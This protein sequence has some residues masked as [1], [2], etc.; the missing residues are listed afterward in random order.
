MS[1]LQKWKEKRLAKKSDAEIEKIFGKM[2][3][4]AFPCGWGQVDDEVQLL[5]E[6][7]DQK[8]PLDEIK[9]ILIHAKGRIIIRMNPHAGEDVSL[10]ES[11]AV[12][13]AS[14][15][16]RSDGKLSQEEAEA[17]CKFCMMKLVDGQA[18]K[19]F[20]VGNAG[21][22]DKVSRKPDDVVTINAKN[23]FQGISMEY[24]WLE[25]EY[26]KQDKD[27]KVLD[28]VHGNSDDGGKSYEIF[29]IS[30]NKHGNKVIAFEISSWYQK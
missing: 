26:G 23:T 25:N 11:D 22:S 27:W 21:L 29:T 30:T 18:T 28:R 9:S 16:G 19:G 12:L 2:F 20:V 7:L 6:I 17:V 10:E 3:H 4:F 1:F 14:I 24:D 15:M 8:L 13:A 5:S